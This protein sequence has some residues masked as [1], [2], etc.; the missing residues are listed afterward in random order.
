MVGGPNG[1]SAI[2]QFAAGNSEWFSD[3]PDTRKSIGGRF[4]NFILCRGEHLAILTRSYL[5]ELAGDSGLT[6]IGIC[7]PMVETSFPDIIDAQVLATEHEP[8][9]DAPRTLIIEAR[10]ITRVTK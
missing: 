2:Q 6:F 3:F 9:P 5:E 7:K 1:D 10:K 4:A 8:T